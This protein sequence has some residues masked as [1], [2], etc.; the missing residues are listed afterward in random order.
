VG[1]GDDSDVF[2]PAGPAGGGTCVTITRRERK[3]GDSCGKAIDM[4]A[5]DV[6]KAERGE[7]MNCSSG[8]EERET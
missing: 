1:S 5:E 3:L 4:R 8:S 6:W 2:E 7:G